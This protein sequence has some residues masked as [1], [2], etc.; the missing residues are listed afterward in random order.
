MQVTHGPHCWQVTMAFICYPG[1]DESHVHSNCYMSAWPL[2][3]GNAAGAATCRI[4][5]GGN[6]KPGANVSPPPGAIPTFA[7]QS[8]H[9]L[10]ELLEQTAC[11][12]SSSSSSS[13]S[14]QGR[15][16]PAGSPLAL[17]WAASSSHAPSDATLPG[18]PAPGLDFLDHLLEGGVLQAASCSFPVMGAAA[19]GLAACDVGGESLLHVGCGDGGLTKMA[20]SK[21]LAVMGVDSDVAVA[22]K[23]G[24]RCCTYATGQPLGPGSLTGVGKQV[25]AVL[26]YT[27]AGLAAERA[28]G[29][30]PGLTAA[31]CLEGHALAELATVL[32]KG[33]R[34]C[35]EAP[36]GGSSR[37]AAEQALAA[38]GFELREWEL[39]GDDGERVRMVAAKL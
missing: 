14:T 34:V 23:R 18:A 17:G 25:D 30:R 35:L 11:S 15:C 33:G 4:A 3:V 31:Q 21:G 10:C 20:G 5:G 2:Q 12:S 32:G 29:I 22:L 8:L 9:E 26:V 1:C 28:D 27:P 37:G 36:G 39:W 19:G 24:L 38:A 13:S 16:I 6:E 7:V